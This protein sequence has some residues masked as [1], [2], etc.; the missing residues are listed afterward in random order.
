MYEDYPNFTIA[1]KVSAKYLDYP[2][3]AWRNLFKEIADTLKE[4]DSTTI[5][6]DETAKV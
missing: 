4:Y 1:R 2:V 3:T 6:E 5:I